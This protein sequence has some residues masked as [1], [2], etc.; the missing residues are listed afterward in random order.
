MRKI[1]V[2]M[3]SGSPGNETAT[4][5]LIH[6]GGI[7]SSSDSSLRTNVAEAHDSTNNSQFLFIAVNRFYLINI[8]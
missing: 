3:E 1:I 6:P 4:K 2:K 7:W 5:P 8:L